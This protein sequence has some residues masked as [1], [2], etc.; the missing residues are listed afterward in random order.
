LLLDYWP[1]NRFARAHEPAVDARRRRW[2]LLFEKL[3]LLALSLASC[4]ITVLAQKVSIAPIARISLPMRLSNALV[5]Y[6]DYL[7]QLFY[8]IDLA[9]L[10]PWEAMRL[11]AGRV[12]TSFLV[13]V[14][15]SAVVVIFRRKGYFLTGWF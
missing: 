14:A 10:Y 3:P 7:R 9:I 2:H 12:I 8:P 6:L 5:S 4:V 11:G 1:L 15:I 13:L